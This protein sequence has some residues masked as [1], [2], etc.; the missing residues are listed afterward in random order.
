M[1][2][3]RR[4]GERMPGPADSLSGP[5]IGRAETWSHLSTL[6]VALCFVI[7]MIDGTNVLLM[8]YLAPSI[9]REWGLAPTSLGIM[10][11]AGLVGMAIGGLAIAP[12]G[13]RFGRRHLILFSLLLMSVGMVI[14]GLSANLIHLV[15][16]RVVV[17]IG[18]GTVLACMTALV[19]EFSP[20]H[21]RS[22]S[23][24]LLQAGYP[25]GATFAGFLTAWALTNYP[26]RSI[27]LFAGFSSLAFFPVVY[28]FLPE[29]ISFLMHAQPAGA[30]EQVNRV[31]R[32][33]NSTPLEAL[34]PVQKSARSHSVLSTLMREGLRHDTLLL[35]TAFFFGYMVL[36]AIV[37][38]IPKFAISRPASIQSRVSMPQQLHRSFPRNRSAGGTCGERP[39]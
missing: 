34:P 13:D 31:R 2:P 36:Y 37:S 11:G 15:L 3:N 22:F 18:I 33:L 4:K 20:P 29:S 1:I 7:N 19:A 5:F 9:A 6:V 28:F 12:L 25:I 26:W 8:S 14:S 21:R 27:L 10:F 38:W 17:G 35:W 23:V 30:L 24:G 39:G 32:R 16:A